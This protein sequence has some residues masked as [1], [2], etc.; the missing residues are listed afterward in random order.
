MWLRIL[1]LSLVVGVFGACTSNSNRTDESAQAVLKEYISL[2]F[3]MKEASDRDRLLT[4]LTGQAK[5][6]LAA[7]SPDQFNQAFLQNK[8][9]FLKLLILED[10]KISATEENVTYEL[11]YIDYGRAD[12]G[13]GAQVTNK[14]LCHLIQSQG[15]W[16]ITEM[17]NIKE[18][19]EYRNEMTFPF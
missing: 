13:Q 1:V 2:S 4:Y 8:R 16:L 11:T 7:W 9:E 12:G 17:R 15:K 10:K 3:Q 18:L 14:K 6:R 5:T 19:V